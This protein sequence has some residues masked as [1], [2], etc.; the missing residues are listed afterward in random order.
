VSVANE[1]IS[2]EMK[3]SAKK[4]YHTEMK[5]T[6]FHD[7]KAEKSQE[8]IRSWVELS[9]KTADLIKEKLPLGENISSSSNRLFFELILSRLWDLTDYFHNIDSVNYDVQMNVF[10]E[11]Q[12]NEQRDTEIINTKLTNAR[13]IKQDTLAVNASKFCD[14]GDISRPEFFRQG[15]C[16]LSLF[17]ETFYYRLS[18][19]NQSKMT[20]ENLYKMATNSNL[21]DGDAG[22][23]LKE[24]ETWLKEFKLKGRAIDIRGKLIWSYDPPVLNKKIPGGNTYR[25]LIHNEHYGSLTRISKNSQQRQ[26]NDYSR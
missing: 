15:S 9:E 3:S 11:S 7:S 21:P 12:K 25:L 24:C 18:N 4:Y 19:I 10:E 6:L 14:F 5:I 13:G 2:Q 26:Q 20:F 1:I 17:M 16:M 8:T 23:T 22:V